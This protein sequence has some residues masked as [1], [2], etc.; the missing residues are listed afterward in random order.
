MIQK[1][2]DISCWLTIL[3][4][5]SKLVAPSGKLMALVEIC[6]LPKGEADITT[7]DGHQDCPFWTKIS[8]IR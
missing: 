6:H 1:R 3:C 4:M 2:G 7:D 8:C 5:S